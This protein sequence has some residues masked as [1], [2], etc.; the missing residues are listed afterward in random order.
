MSS[1]LKNKQ[2]SGG[3]KALKDALNTTSVILRIAMILLVF[4]FVFSGMKNLEQ[5]EQ[6]VVLRFGSE[7]GAVREK[8]GMQFALPYPVDQM[9][10]VPV[11]R[12][13]SLTSSTFMYKKTQMEEVAPF[14]KPGVDGYLLTADGNI[15]HCESTLKYQVEDISSYLFSLKRDQKEVIIGNLLD[16][17]VLK[18]AAQLTLNQTLDKKEL[19]AESKLILQKQLNDVAAGVRVELLDI[20]LSV[21]RQVEE[22]R[23]EVLKAR[24]KAD[25]LKAESDK[26]VRQTADQTENDLVKIQY[27][28][29]IWKTRMLGRAQADLKTFEKLLVDYR[30]NPEQVKAMLLRNAM[31]EVSGELEEVF[32][33][34]G[35][36]DRELR[37]QMSRQPVNDKTKVDEK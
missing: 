32:V 27:S 20:R 13:Q 36:G 9:I 34:D 10:V 8:A 24:N 21:P 7:S 19:I 37:I 12:T 17:A 3:L 15:L 11:G 22:N 14:L 6:A 18:S 25:S 33:F 23:L 26:Y 1:E 28:A 29:K 35:S 31:A 5:Y 16:N 2:E 30:K 4:A